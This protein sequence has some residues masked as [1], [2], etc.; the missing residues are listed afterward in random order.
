MSRE[1][2]Q[3]ELREESDSGPAPTP[4]SA[5]SANPREGDRCLRLA[6]ERSQGTT[7]D[8]GLRATFLRAHV[9]DALM[10]S[11]Q[12]RDDLAKWSDSVLAN[13][14]VSR[15][16]SGSGTLFDGTPNA[17][18]R[19]GETLLVA[20]E[21][22]ARQPD[23]YAVHKAKAMALLSRVIAT[24]RQDGVANAAADAADA[25]FDTALAACRDFGLDDPELREAGALRYFAR[26]D[27]AG[28]QGYVRSELA[29]N[30]DW[31]SGH[32]HLAGI[33]WRRRD[34][35]EAKTHLDR[36]LQLAP[37]DVRFLDAARRT[38]T[39]KPG[40]KGIFWAG[41]SVGFSDL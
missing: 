19:L 26:D 20:E 4:A 37:G 5:P 31:P 28:A 39:A 6:D 14:L 38:A 18:L 10:G 23:A 3:A 36:A 21:L 40:E 24:P 16:G 7:R 33:A 12:T 9:V 17:A 1:K 2:A 41:M 30:P 25:A 27:T 32:Y 15:L 34:G 22:A 29:S 11:V 35:A 8:A 13:A